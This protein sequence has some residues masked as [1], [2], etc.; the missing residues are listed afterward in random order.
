MLKYAVIGCP[1]EHSRSPQIYHELFKRHGIDAAFVRMRVDPDEFGSIREL[2]K[3]LS[4]FAVTMPY[5]RAVIPFL[6]ALSPEAEACGA[7]N[8]VERRGERLIGHNTDGDGLIDALRSGGVEVGGRRVLI[9]GRGGAARS[10]AHAVMRNGGEAV[11]LVRKLSGSGDIPEALFI[12]VELE[13]LSPADIF[14]NATP[15]GM[16]GGPQFEDFGFLPVIGPKA[17]FDMVYRTD[18]E[19]PLTAFASS[20]GIKAFGGGEMLFRQALRAFAIW[21]GFDPETGVSE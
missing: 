1:V 12:G 15:L 7:V 10:A 21:F 3:E 2:T 16:E 4:G 11:F 17:V 18:N 19:T 20:I 9:L 14:I 8:I 5:K 13:K 6:D